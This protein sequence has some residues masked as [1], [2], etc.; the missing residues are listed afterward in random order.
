MTGRLICVMGPSG[1]GKDSVLAAARRAAP[2]GLWFAHRY[3][4]RPADGTENHV[5]LSAAEFAER[6]DAGGFA[7]H[8]QSHGFS[9]GIGLE[10]DAWLRMG[11]DVVINGSRAAF[12]EALTRYPDLLPVVITV[13][14]ATLRR[15]LT[16]RGREDAA[17]VEARLRRNAEV[18]VSHPRLVTI[19]NDRGI[20]DA[21]ADFLT[22]VIR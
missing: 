20:D 14:E 17:A 12:G 4:T 6:R 9:Y 16:A 10:I 22:A 19:L 21:A 5:A 7:L 1:A 13:G 15:R 18:A 3:I 11:R 8:W 2:D